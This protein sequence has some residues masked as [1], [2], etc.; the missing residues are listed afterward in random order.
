MS[1]KKTDTKI[2]KRTLPGNF[3][4]ESIRASVAKYRDTERLIRELQQSQAQDA[5]DLVDQTIGTDFSDPNAVQL[6]SVVDLRARLK[7]VKIEALKAQNENVFSE[8]GILLRDLTTCV[9]KLSRAASTAYKD[10]YESRILASNCD[11]NTKSSQLDNLEKHRNELQRLLENSRRDADVC[12]SAQTLLKIVDDFSASG[13]VDGWA[14][15]FN[16]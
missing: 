4:P 11:R 2:P 6:L 3:N 16:G 12:R 1:E 8:V 9:D 13:T 10:D 14:L 7:L 15:E 5:D